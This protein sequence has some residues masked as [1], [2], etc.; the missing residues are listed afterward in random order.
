VSL[1]PPAERRELRAVVKMQ[2]KVLRTEVKQRE[3]ELIAQ[4]ERRLVD[5]YR[6]EDKKV[7]DLNWRIRQVVEQAGKDIDDLVKAAGDEFDGG[8]WQRLGQLGFGSF[9]TR[10]NEDRG[11][12]HTAMTAGVK[13]QVQDA[14]LSL[15]RQEADLLRSLALESLESAEAQAFL[16]RIP[17]VGELVPS[18]RL[19]EIEAAFDARKTT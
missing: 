16:G 17:T 2:F 13:A 11:Q 9:V 6:D 5:K 1:I 15:D 4:A 10:K 14:L 18:S 7:D 12:L 19:R 3:A 8:R